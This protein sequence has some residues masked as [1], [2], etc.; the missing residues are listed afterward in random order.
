METPQVLL[1]ERVKEKARSSC[2]LKVMAKQ[3][4]QQQVMETR[5]QLQV[6]ERDC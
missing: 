6:M 4:L 3:Q 1:M 5:P 2:Q